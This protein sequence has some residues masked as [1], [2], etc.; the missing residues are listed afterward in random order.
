MH[1]NISRRDIDMALSRASSSRRGL[2][3]QQIAIGQAVQGLE[4]FAGAG[5]VGLIS[6]RF[7]SQTVRLGSVTVPLD[8]TGGVLGHLLAFYLRGS[9]ASEHL[10]NLSTGAMAAWFTKYMVGYGGI[11]REKAGLSR[12]AGDSEH[13]HLYGGMPASHAGTGAVSMES[14]VQPLTEAELVSMSHGVK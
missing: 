1:L 7:G 10:H 8:L 4:I 14:P 13:G 3:G 2:S 11:L 5:A 9:G 6:G 12:V